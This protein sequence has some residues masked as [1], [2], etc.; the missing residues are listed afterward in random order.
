MAPDENG[1][2]EIPFYFTGSNREYYRSALA[3]AGGVANVKLQCVVDPACKNIKMEGM[4]VV[5]VEI[6]VRDE[7]RATIS[8]STK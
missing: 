5:D 6:I 4:D 2:I 8:L 3:S 1:N 7:P